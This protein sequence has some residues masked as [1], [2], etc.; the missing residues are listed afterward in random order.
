MTTRLHSCMRYAP[1]SLFYHNINRLSAYTVNEASHWMTDSLPSER[2]LSGHDP[3]S[4]DDQQTVGTLAVSPATVTFVTLETR[5]YAVVA[6]PRTLRSPQQPSRWRRHGWT[7]MATWRRRHRPVR[8]ALVQSRTSKRAT[9]WSFVVRFFVGATFDVEV[10]VRGLTVRDDVN[11]GARHFRAQI[12]ATPQLFQRL[13][14]YR[15]YSALSPN[16]PSLM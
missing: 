7:S 12:A 10:L 14:Y 8:I 13:E 11:E 9:I 2:D 1:L 16:C 6:T 15:S 4:F 5:H 3:L